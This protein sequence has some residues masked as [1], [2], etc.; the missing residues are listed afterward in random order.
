MRKLLSIFVFVLSIASLHAHEGMWLPQLIGKLNHQQMKE[1]GLELSAEDIYSVNQSSLKDAIVHFNEGCTASLIS[2][3]GL[4]LTNHHCGYS[5]IQSHSSLAN[6]YLRDGFWAM[7]QEEELTNPGVTASIVQYLE[8]VTNRVMEGTS[9]AMNTETRDSLIKANAQAVLANWPNPDNYA[10]EIKPFFFGNQ[11]ILIAKEVFKDVRLVGAPPSSI[12]KYGADTDNWMWP[13]HTGDFS[14]FRIYA[15]ADNKPAELAETNQPYRPKQHLK[16]NLDGVQEGDFTMVY[17]FPGSTQ[18]YL[19]ASEVKNIAEVYNPLRI[20]V[21]D[22]ILAILDAKMRKDEATRIKYA[23]KYARISNSWKRWKG[24][25]KGLKETRGIEKIRDEEKAFAGKMLRDKSL[26]KY[27][28]VLPQLVVLYEQRI[29]ANSERYYYI[30]A[31]YFGLEMM[32]HMLRYRSLVELYEADNEEALAAEGAKLAPGLQGFYKDYEP[33][34]EQQVMK[35]ILPLYLNNISMAPLPKLIAKLKSKDAEELNA[36]IEKQ[37]AKNPVLEEE[38]WA[39][40]LEDNPAKAA[41]KLKKSTAFQLSMAM[42]KHYREVANPA[43]QK[44]DQQIDALQAQY[45]EGLQKAFPK[46]AYYPDANSSLRVAYGKVKSYHPEDAVTYKSR[47]YLEGVMEK[48]VPGDYEFD[49]PEKLIELYHKRDYG[50]YAENGKLPVC[51]VATNHTTGGN[52]GS[53]VLNA[54]GELVGLNFDRAWEGVM[55]DMYFDTTRCRNVMV[56]LR[57]VLFITDKFADAAYLVEEMDLVHNPKQEA[58]RSTEDEKE[59]VETVQ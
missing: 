42:Y 48:Y 25:I 3:K 37:F 34:L 22:K 20:A 21:R 53:P 10:L 11:Y 5:Q 59:S 29:P 40:L 18:Q 45:V 26:K 41:K 14:M 1:M 13:R 49:L 44:I 35:E 28:N 55:S 54:R 27:E 8:D 6:N 12:G 2:D 15:G 4:L 23:S 17:G 50:Q 9:D 33:A 52:S 46:K 43:V 24:E 38:A 51:F 47:T 7:S 57:Y 56:D 58:A 39:K 31:G 32:R 30:E 19:P 36:F 16:I